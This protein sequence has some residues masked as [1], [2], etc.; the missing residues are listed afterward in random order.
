MGWLLC[1]MFALL[2]SSPPASPVDGTF[3]GKVIDPPLNQPVARGWIF[4]QGRNHMRRVEVAHAIVVFGDGIPAHQ[5][6][7]CNS[8]CLSA[9]QEVRV[10]ARQDAAGEWRARRVEILYMPTQ[11]AQTSSKS[12]A[13]PIFTA[14]GSLSWITKNSHSASHRIRLKSNYRYVGVRQYN[15]PVFQAGLVD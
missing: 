1:L 12:L 8:E 15:K 5:R 9:G 14:R 11:V 3:R 2:L 7:K 13:L 10:T 4:V 6:H